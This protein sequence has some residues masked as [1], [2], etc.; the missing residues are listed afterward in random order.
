M[1]CLVING[2]RPRRGGREGVGRVGM[3][4]RG[5]AGMGIRERAGM[6]ARGRAGKREG[7]GVRLGEEERGGARQ[8]A[9]NLGSFFIYFFYHFCVF[10]FF[11][12]LSLFTFYFTCLSRFGFPL[13]LTLSPPLSLFL[14]LLCITSLYSLS[15]LPLF[16][17]PS[18]HPLSFLYPLKWLP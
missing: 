18:L 5:R 13:Q 17:L 8:L 7:K 11:P 10:V 6:G 9:T 1:S 3:G 14:A 16:Y 15:P 2:W 12:S 4:V